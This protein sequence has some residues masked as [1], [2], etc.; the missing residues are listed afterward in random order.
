MTTIPHPTYPLQQEMRRDLA[1]AVDRAD[2][3]RIRR[4]YARVRDRHHPGWQKRYSDEF[5]AW[6]AQQ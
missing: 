1:H 6:L 4:H 2:I 3:E 5:K